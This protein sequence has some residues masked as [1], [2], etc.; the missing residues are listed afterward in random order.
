[1]W[2]SVFF[3]ARGWVIAPL[4]PPTQPKRV[5]DTPVQP[6]GKGRLTPAALFPFSVWWFAAN[7][8]GEPGDVSMR[9]AKERHLR[10]S[11]T[12]RDGA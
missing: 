11:R 10:I 3:N 2:G 12:S 7:A 4:S 6:L 8:R 5:A 9:Q 1:M